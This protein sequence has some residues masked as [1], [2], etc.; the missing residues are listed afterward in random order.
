MSM[1]NS[2]NGYDQYS[3]LTVRTHLIGKGNK[4]IYFFLFQMDDW[5]FPKN[6]MMGK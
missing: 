1:E 6:E 2:T 4:I 3:G 5:Y